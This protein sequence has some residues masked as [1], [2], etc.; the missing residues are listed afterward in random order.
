M[1]GVC[2][3]LTVLFCVRTQFL[4]AG[5]DC[6]VNR[7]RISGGDCQRKSLKG[8]G[9]VL[10][11]LES[12]KNK[13]E[14]N[15]TKQLKRNSKTKK[16]NAILYVLF[17]VNGYLFCFSLPETSKLRHASV[18]CLF[19]ISQ[20]GYSGAVGVWVS[21]FPLSIVVSHV[22]HVSHVSQCFDSV[23]L[24]SQLHSAQH[25]ILQRRQGQGIN[26]AGFF[27]DAAIFGLDQFDAVIQSSSG[28]GMRDAGCGCRFWDSRSPLEDQILFPPQQLFECSRDKLVL[29]DTL[30]YGSCD[31]CYLTCYMMYQ[32]TSFVRRPVIFVPH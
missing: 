15:K 31:P 5:T 3:I 27:Q 24:G 7:S 19:S 32:L 2:G 11:K 10:W 23:S 18:C 22:S 25:K 28:S 21:F 4:G 20:F 1:V 17:W 13:T 9:I 16:N 6:S 30:R 8:R 29:N 26:K 14:Q 12:K